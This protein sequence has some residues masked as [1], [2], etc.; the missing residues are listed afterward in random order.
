MPTALQNESPASTG[1]EAGH[2]R[3]MRRIALVKSKHTAFPRFLQLVVR[4]RG[5]PQSPAVRTAQN[6]APLTTKHKGVQP[7]MTREIHSLIR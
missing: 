6:Y 3:T 7:W 2:R 5:F 4:F 1:I